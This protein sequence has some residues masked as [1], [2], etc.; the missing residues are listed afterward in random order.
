MGICT[1]TGDPHYFTFDGAIAHFQGTCAYQLTHTCKEASLSGGL[2]F[3]VE[4]TNR[5]FR[6]RRVSFVTRVEVWLNNQDFQAHVVLERGQPV[7]VS[8]D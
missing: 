7:K 8:R 2:S 1:A 5:N 4:A 3:R 6:S